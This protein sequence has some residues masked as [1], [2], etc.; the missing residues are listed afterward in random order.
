MRTP[1]AT[2]VVTV[3]VLV[4]LYN[5]SITGGCQASPRMFCPGNG[6]TRGQMAVFITRAFALR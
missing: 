1:G 5:R 3:Q 2:A 6:I 4:D